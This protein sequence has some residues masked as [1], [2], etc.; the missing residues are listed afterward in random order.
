[1]DINGY[2]ARGRRKIWNKC[3]Y[4]YWGVLGYGEIIPMDGK[5]LNEANSGEPSKN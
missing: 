5:F 4:A 1:M 2:M 3:S